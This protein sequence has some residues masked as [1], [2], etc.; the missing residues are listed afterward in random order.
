MKS[1]S[2]EKLQ[3]TIK[4][5]DATFLNLVVEDVYTLRFEIDVIL[6]SI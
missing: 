5:F 3:I 2:K 1:S 4:G 6:V